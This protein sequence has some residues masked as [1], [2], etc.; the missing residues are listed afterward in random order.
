MSNVRIDPENVQIHSLA[1]EIVQAALDSLNSRCSEIQQMAQSEIPIL[2]LE[3][4]EVLYIL[5][6]NPNGKTPDGVI[7]R[8]AEFAWNPPKRR[9]KPSTRRKRF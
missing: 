2:E 5:F 9:R 4:E 7:Y 1:P 8:Q 3:P 6:G